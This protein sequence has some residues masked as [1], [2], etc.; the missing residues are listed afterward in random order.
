[1]QRIAVIG[2]TG[3]GGA[4]AVRTCKRLRENGYMAEGYAGAAAARQSGL[5]PAEGGMWNWVQ[6]MFQEKEALLFIGACGIAVRSIAPFLKSKWED[7]AV[8]VMDEKGEAV[9]P[10]LSGHAGGGNALALQVAALLGASPVLT[11]ATDVNGQFA[12]DVFARKNGL[13]IREKALAKEV[14]SRILQG[15]R[16]PVVTEEP[17]YGDW[18]GALYK[19]EK[20]VVLS[21]RT[22]LELH[23]PK[24][25]EDA[26][27]ETSGRSLG[28][29]I[30]KDGRNRWEKTLHLYPAQLTA[31]VGCRRGTSKDAILEALQQAAAQIGASLLDIRLVASIDLKAKE[32]GLLEAC[33]ELE[34]PFQ[35]FSADTLLQAEGDFTAS[36]FVQEITGVDNVCE[37]AAV[38]GS[39]GGAL[40]LKKQV[41]SGVTVALAKG[42]QEIWF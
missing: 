35:C 13:K 41:F 6:Q 11:T 23:N 4:L 42:R 36:P 30:G 19:E 37:R 5:L 10:L 8:L 1:M 21:E 2:F 12:V 27:A 29:Y 39:E 3:Q 24:V 28:I 38:T 32:T 17:L 7:P 33:R 20:T 14:S 34:V 9:I 22:R 40:V 26:Q 18:P 16:L 25:L 15:E 31:G